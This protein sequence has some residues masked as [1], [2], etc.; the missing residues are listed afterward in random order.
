MTMNIGTDTGSL[1]NHL[2]SGMYKQPDPEIGM[3]VTVLM[4]TDRRSGTIVKMSKSKKSLW[5]S[6]D[7]VKRTDKNGMSESQEY[8]CTPNMDIPGTEYT[9]RKNGRYVMKGCDMH[10]EHLLVGKRNNYF[11]FT[12]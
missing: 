5:I 7:T 11:D 2:M 8:E 3:G 10:G 6:R 4:W 1:V 9:L 12:F